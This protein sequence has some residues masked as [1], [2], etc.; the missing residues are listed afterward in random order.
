MM[1]TEILFIN[2]E[3]NL[4]NMISDLGL[5]QTQPPPGM[6]HDGQLR[7]FPLAFPMLEERGF[8]DDC[9]EKH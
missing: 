5:R 7:N 6:T 1:N 9:A 3:L 4:K 2:N 8:I